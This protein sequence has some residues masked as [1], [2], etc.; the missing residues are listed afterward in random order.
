MKKEYNAPVAEMMEFDYE[1]NVVASGS[2]EIPVVVT[3]YTGTG[4][5]WVGDHGNGKGKEGCTKLARC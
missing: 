1:E 2:E 5:G 3:D 4:S